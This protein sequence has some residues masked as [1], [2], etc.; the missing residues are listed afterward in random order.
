MASCFKVNI[1][2]LCGLERRH[3]LTVNVTAFDHSQIDVGMMLVFQILNFIAIPKL[4]H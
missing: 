1:L 2:H 4:L 3:F